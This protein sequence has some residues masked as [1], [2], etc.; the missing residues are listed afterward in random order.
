[1]KN[2]IILLYFSCRS[3]LTK[4]VLKEEISNASHGRNEVIAP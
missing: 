2:K 3:M 4:A 1:M